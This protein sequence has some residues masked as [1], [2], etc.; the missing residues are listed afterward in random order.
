MPQALVSPFDS[1]AVRAG[2][3]EKL[4]GTYYRIEI[5]VPASRSGATATT[6][7]CSLVRRRPAAR[8]DLKADRAGASCA[9][10]SA[11]LE[12]W[13]GRWLRDPPW[14]M[15]APELHLMAG[16]RWTEWPSPPWPGTQLRSDHPRA[17]TPYDGGTPS[18][19]AGRTTESANCST[20]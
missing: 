6:S 16:W 14:R 12:E 11:W 2:R 13:A 20:S 10:S 17:A 4:F 9:S 7:T 18:H 5:Y 19:G 8:V 1:L 15:L 3:L